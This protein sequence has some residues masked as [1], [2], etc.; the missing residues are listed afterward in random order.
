MRYAGRLMGDPAFRPE[1]PA[2]R[3]R[4][5]R[6]PAVALVGALAL[7]ACGGA[8][9]LL[10]EVESEA[11]A[12]VYLLGTY[13]FGLSA[14]ADLPPSV[15][16][17]FDRAAVFQNEA[18]T[19]FVEPNVLLQQ[20]LLPPDERL[21]ARLSPAAFGALVAFLDP[22]PASRLATLRPWIVASMLAA[23]LIEP[24]E[25]IDLSL[26]DAAE[27]AG[28]ELRSFE[29]PE[30]QVAMLNRLPLEEAIP[31]LE[32]Q[33]ADLEGV[34]RALEANI[35]HYRHGNAQA[36]AELDF[37]P[38]SESY[39]IL[40]HQRNLAWLPQI[41]A[42]LQGKAPAFVAVGISHVLGPEGL[43]ALLR[44]GG[45]RVRRLSAHD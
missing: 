35:A 37:A 41:E 6:L 13:H 10:W 4:G 39:E 20:A 26:L 1:L 11:G 18:D 2:L 16:R 22:F 30:Q 19:R 43:V 42:L 23:K 33:L 14:R 45:H 9:P 29:T 27:R 12:P 25:A 8:P 40:L 38:G 21:D 3:R 32:Q 7:A 5:R 15:W 31:A 34:R 36:L 24:Q 17:Y 28:K 44:A